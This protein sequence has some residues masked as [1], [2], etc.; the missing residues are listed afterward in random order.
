[1]NKKDNR[2]KQWWRSRRWPEPQELAMTAFN[3][4]VTI[5]FRLGG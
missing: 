2:F 1:M 3:L 4:A 5:F